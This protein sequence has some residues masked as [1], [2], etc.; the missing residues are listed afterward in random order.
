MLDLGS[1]F[2]TTLGGRIDMS[3]IGVHSG[4]PVSISLLPADCDTGIIFQR[5]DLSDD[6][7]IPARLGS[8]SATSLCTVVGDPAGSHVMTIEHL[9]SALSGLGVD[10]VIIEM[11]G[12]EVP[13]MDGSSDYFVDAID[14]VGIVSQ[15]SLRRYI[16]VLRDV[17]LDVGSS[18]GLFT[19]YDGRHYDI[20]ID[21][22]SPI[23]GHQ[24]YATDLSPDIY[25]TEISRARTFGFM[26][27]VERY[28]SSGF[29]LGA[30]LENSVV[31]C[32]KNSVVNPEGLRFTDEFVRHKLLDAIGDL[33]L[34]GATILGSFR[35]HRGGH[36]L[37]VMALEALISDKDA[38]EWVEG[39]DTAVVSRS[40]AP[41][42][43]LAYAS[44]EG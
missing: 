21:F 11:D 7:D 34:C 27:D 25:R 3:G 22:D 29:A 30:S 4:A 18:W 38:W 19:P 28:W 20:E 31:I 8:V 10:N 17:R 36:K 26:K 1:S 35:S 16:R 39:D 33:S 32:D 42:S 14:S 44:D 15:K 40:P 43:E 2:Q 6:V 24:R 13:I 9:L 5:S 41:E 37:N 12:P 23:I